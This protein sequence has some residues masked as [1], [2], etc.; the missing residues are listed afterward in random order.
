M[1]HA[2]LPDVHLKPAVDLTPVLTFIGGAGYTD[3]D[4]DLAPG[5]TFKVGINS[6]AN[7]NSNSKIASFIVVRTFNNTPTTVF[8]DDNI[9]EATF[10]WEQDLIAN[11]QSGEERWSFTVTDKDG[12]NINCTINW[13]DNNLPTIFELY[14]NETT[15]SVT[16]LNGIEMEL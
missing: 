12:D 16:K 2:W 15:T 11:T 1:V 8:E 7:S 4:A 14:N 9:N 6:S 13:N 5:S 3:A 10:T